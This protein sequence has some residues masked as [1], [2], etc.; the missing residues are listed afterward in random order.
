MMRFRTHLR[1][2]LRAWVPVA[3]PLL[4]LL[5]VLPGVAMA[6]GTTR[7]D[8]DERVRAVSFSGS[9]AFDD[10]TLAASILTHEPGILK[11]LLGI[12]T[13]P[14][15]DSLEMRRDALR[16][17]VLHRQAGGFVRPSRPICSSARTACG[18]ASS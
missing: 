5:S 1:D 8:D 17:A 10:M 15:L 2:F 6:Q 3:L 4:L 14:C 11:R 13:A 12:G 16:I 7:C 9:P 18:C